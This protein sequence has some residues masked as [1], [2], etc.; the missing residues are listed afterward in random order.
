MGY[1]WFTD[2]YSK[3]R[4]VFPIKSTSLG[5]AVFEKF[6]AD[7]KAEGLIQGTVVLQ[8]DNAMLT[9]AFRAAC[10]HAGV[11]PQAC[12]PNAHWQ[13]GIAE[14]DFRTR[15]SVQCDRSQQ[16]TTTRQLQKHLPDRTPRRGKKP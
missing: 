9:Q 8:G 10:R 4:W 12:A 13:N 2:R 15:T 14:R 7:R 1:W 6:I 3:Y 16:T 5:P 11:V